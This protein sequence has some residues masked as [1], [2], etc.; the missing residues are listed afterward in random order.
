MDLCLYNKI[1]TAQLNWSETSSDIR[2]SLS[3]LEEHHVSPS[4]KLFKT[5]TQ[6]SDDIHG[7]EKLH[8]RV[9]EPLEI[10]SSKTIECAYEGL[11]GLDKIRLDQMLE[12]DLI[13]S[14]R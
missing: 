14:H 8:E 1:Y 2:C 10:S 9:S 12:T 5:T 6:K 4:M 7:I 3:Q 11:V 13:S